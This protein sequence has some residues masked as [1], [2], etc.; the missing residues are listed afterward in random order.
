[1]QENYFCNSN[2]ICCYGV[3][4]LWQYNMS[5][6]RMNGLGR[7]TTEGLAYT[8]FTNSGGGGASFTATT[9]TIKD[10]CSDHDIIWNGNHLVRQNKLHVNKTS[11]MQSDQGFHC[12]QIELFGYAECIYGERRPGWYFAHDIFLLDAA[13]IISR[14]YRSRWRFTALTEALNGSDSDQTI[15]WKQCQRGNR[16]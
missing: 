14:L 16:F 6:K 9:H 3:L 11:E 13:Y 2:E 1:M 15:F 10:R 5:C 12:P 7:K 4:F 8:R